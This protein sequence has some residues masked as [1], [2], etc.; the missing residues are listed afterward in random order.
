MR[1]W[2]FSTLHFFLSAKS[3]IIFNF[4]TFYPAVHSQWRRG[5]ANTTPSNSHILLI[6]QQQQ[7]AQ[8]AQQRNKIN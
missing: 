7:Q 3:W 8:Q 4:V 6:Q 2:V 1:H 5:G